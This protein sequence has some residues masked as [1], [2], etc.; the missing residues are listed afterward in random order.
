MS[1]EVRWFRKKPVAI[2]AHCFGGGE[3]GWQVLMRWLEALGLE[4]E[5]SDGSDGSQGMWLAEDNEALI[6]DT[7]EGEH[8]AD[9]GDWIVCGVKDE[10]YPVKPDIFDA[11]YE[12][13]SPLDA[14]SEPQS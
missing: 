10:M 14:S 5:D 8:R 9:P 2:R 7:L 12:G 13:I 3:V 11:T 6:I 4:G 1:S